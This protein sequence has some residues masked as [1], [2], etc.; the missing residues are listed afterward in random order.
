MINS[1]PLKTLLAISV[2]AVV[3]S[4]ANADIAI[5]SD[6]T[7]AQKQTNNVGYSF[8][9]TGLSGE[10][11]Q[12]INGLG[13]QMPLGLS[14]QV[15]VPKHWNI[16]LNSGAQDQL[17]SWQGDKGWPYVLE[18][19]ARRNGLNVKVDWSSKVV[20][21]FS[22]KASQLK[23]TADAKKAVAGLQNKLD[24]RKVLDKDGNVVKG[25]NISI[26]EIYANANVKPLD[27]R[28]RTFVSNVYNGGMSADDS[29]RFILKPNLMLSDNLALWGEYTGWDVKW[30][31]NADYNI[32]NEIMLKGSLRDSVLQAL[33]LYSKTD[34]PLAAKFFD[35]N[36][37]VE[38]TD[39]NYK[40]PKTV[41]PSGFEQ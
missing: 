7:E 5:F 40:D 15:I 9:Q 8:S 18:D 25:K 2:L 36:K 37:V 32:T 34:H 3:A 31:A 26:E 19:L 17:V 30:N 6:A 39:F 11:A 41:I 1:K 16:N 28:I 33:K 13:E 38:I 22:P 23:Q 20:D 4:H 24:D 10:K 35:G 21:V 27:G 29:A 14:L 12:V